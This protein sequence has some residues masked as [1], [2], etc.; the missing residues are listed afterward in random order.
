[1]IGVRPPGSDVV[2]FR[3]G[4]FL[5]AVDPAS[6][7]GA[8][9]QVLEGPVEM[10]VSLTDACGV[11]CPA[12]YVDARPDGATP[13]LATI[14]ERL[15][16][17][18]TEGV[19]TVAFGGGEPLLRADLA[20]IA[21][22]SHRLGLVAVVTTSGFGPSGADVVRQLARFDQVNLSHDGVDGGYAAVRGRDGSERVAGLTARLVDAGVRV[23]WNVV[24]TRN[25]FDALRATVAAAAT[26]G[27][28]D[29]QLLRVKPAGRATDLVY[30][31]LR[32]TEAQITALPGLLAEL[33][34]GAPSIRVDC[35][36][37]PFLVPVDA[38][39]DVARNFAE[40]MKQTGVF[41]C[42]AGR[43]L[44]ALRTDGTR[45][46]CSF[47]ARSDGSDALAFHRALPAP[48]NT[49]VL[50][51]VCRGGCRVV[52]ARSGDPEGRDVECPRVRAYRGVG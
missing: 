25:N 44:A 36:L 27:V 45:A 46:G 34:S 28:A 43:S 24:L 30:R 52:A 1:M 19:R 9:D 11:G 17:I 4:N 32:L 35:A 5:V 31:S 20:E 12:C 42:E 50:H 41:G 21:D 51:E 40:R 10:H 38:T 15:R 48:C 29:V 14:L 3:A 23:G 49:C 39:D 18:A 47:E 33:V 37:I 8:R 7:D 2:W 13:A 16:A 26:L 22:E 6:V